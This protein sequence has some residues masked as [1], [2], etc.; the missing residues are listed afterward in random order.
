MKI[1]AA[2]FCKTGTKSLNAALT[3]LGYDVYDY[4]EHFW[5]HGKEWQK[6]Y[7]GNGSVD[8]FKKMYKNVDVAM[9]TPVFLFWEEIFWAFPEAKV[10][11]VRVVK[12]IY[13]KIKV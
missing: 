7:D 5:Y 1:I 11:E 13:V 12:T 3:D 9:D 2:G 6:I 10:T 4:L 8:T